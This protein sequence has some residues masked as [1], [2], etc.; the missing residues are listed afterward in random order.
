MA[1]FY[2]RYVL[3]RT[4]ET[5]L[6]GY[7]SDN[8]IV[9]GQFYTASTGLQ[10]VGNFQCFPV[11]GECGCLIS[12]IHASSIFEPG[13]Y[14]NHFDLAGSRFSTEY[15]NDRYRMHGT[16]RSSDGRWSFK[17]H[18]HGCAG[19]TWATN[20]STAG[21]ACLRG[22]TLTGSAALT[23]YTCACGGSAVNAYPQYHS[24]H[25]RTQCDT[26]ICF[27]PY[28]AVQMT[29]ALCS[30]CS[31]CT[32]C[33]NSG[34]AHCEVTFG[35]VTSTFQQSQARCSSI[36]GCGS[37][38][39]A[40][41]PLE[42]CNPTG[43]YNNEG[44]SD[45]IIFGSCCRCW[46]TGGGCRNVNVFGAYPIWN[47][48]RGSIENGLRVF[49]AA[50]ET[51]VYYLYYN[52]QF[53]GLQGT[54]TATSTSARL[55]V[56][57]F[58]TGTAATT[59]LATWKKG[60]GGLVIP[61]QADLSNATS[62]RFYWIMFNGAD[63]ATQTISIFRPTLNFGAGTMTQGSA[64]SLTM[65]AGQQQALYAALGYNNTG[66]GV[67]NNG[68]FRRQTTH[69][70]WFSTDSE[71]NK[72]L[73]LGVYNTNAGGYITSANNFNNAA[74]R[75]SIFKIWSWSLNDGETTAAFLGSV[76]LATYAPRY[77]CPLNDDWT[78]VYAGS[79]LTNDIVIT[80]NET[81]GLYQYQNTMPHIASR[82]FK[83]KD[84][85]W[86]VQVEDPAAGSPTVYGNYIDIITSSVGQTLVITATTTSYIYSGTTINGNITVNVYNYLGER[87]AKTVNLTV[88]GPTASPG[89]TFA[90]DEYTTTVTT[91]ASVDT[92]VSIKVISAASAKIIGTVS[93]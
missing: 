75:G 64:Y 41:W 31:S 17:S 44:L 59:T 60:V 37:T 24:M 86:A 47:D 26:Y 49:L 56:R 27:V 43:R 55:E 50:N 48:A 81:T 22:C 45:S 51:F 33:N 34:G 58:N 71:D 79:S 77:F 88:V 42:A 54:D 11:V 76:D 35:D 16:L 19:T 23:A 10:Q 69:R 29:G 53:G 91:S 1:K 36:G 83:D 8:L 63:T 62:H 67:L 72:R 5:V 32:C 25:V 21:T 80:L 66:D 90:N 84:G 61:S 38:V 15:E 6:Y 92:T 3:P 87:V 85:R 70:V 4:D 7:S 89:I 20:P 65:T 9:N 12:P 57:M 39:V 28:S 82:L 93:E 46:F 2:Q 30:T 13:T 74:Q 68:T 18:T 78:V 52:A 40:C 14:A 73:H